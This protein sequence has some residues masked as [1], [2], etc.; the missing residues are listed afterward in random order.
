M[1]NNSSTKANM[2]PQNM[3]HYRDHNESSGDKVVVEQVR[4]NGLAEE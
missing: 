4:L 3:D 1:D 2:A